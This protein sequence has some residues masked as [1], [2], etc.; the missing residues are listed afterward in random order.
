MELLEGFLKMS[1]LEKTEFYQVSLMGDNWY[2]VLAYKYVSC[3]YNI[4]TILETKG[5]ST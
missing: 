2:N 5:H 4:M 1:L 3:Y